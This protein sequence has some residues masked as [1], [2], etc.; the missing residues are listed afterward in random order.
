MSARLPGVFLLATD[1][2]PGVSWGSGAPAATVP[3][4][5][6][7]PADLGNG[8][9]PVVPRDPAGRG[10]QACRNSSAG[11][12]TKP[13]VVVPMLTKASLTRRRKTSG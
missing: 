2:T 3:R 10:A 12:P 11:R 5:P 4:A 1:L 13:R 6:G 7:D 8:H 9:V